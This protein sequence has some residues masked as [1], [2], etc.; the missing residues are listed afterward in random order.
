[1]LPD[2]LTRVKTARAFGAFYAVLGLW[3]KNNNPASIHVDCNKAKLAR[4]NQAKGTLA[5]GDRR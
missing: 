2:G 1:M 3:H 4:S 5:I